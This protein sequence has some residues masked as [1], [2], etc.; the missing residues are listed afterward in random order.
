MKFKFVVSDIPYMRALA[1]AIERADP[2]VFIE[3]GRDCSRTESALIVTDI[4]QEEYAKRTSNQDD[5]GVVFLDRTISPAYEELA[6]GGPFRICKYCRVSELLAQLSYYYYLW[7]GRN[8]SVCVDSKVISVI[9]D[10]N[11]SVAD[12]F[13]QLFARHYLYRIG[14]NVLVLCFSCIDRIAAVHDS[15]D[16]FKRLVYYAASGRDVPLDAFF[17]RDNYGVCYLRTP[18]GI[19]PIYKADD[20]TMNDL[21]RLITGSLFD[22]V[23][24]DIGT[25]FSERNIGLI[26]RSAA[27]FWLYTENEDAVS[28]EVLLNQIITTSDG[29]TTL[30]AGRGIDGLSLTI[31]ERIRRSFGTGGYEEGNSQEVSR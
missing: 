7:S 25:E 27:K 2:N 29:L 18:Y 31:D 8:D 24:L 6:P 14:G 5:K 17:Y 13:S 9:T 15:E 23:I 21:M 26:N 22:L 12:A 3:I 20:T 28:N 4:S 10:R 11:P 16:M 1:G 30:Y 19:N